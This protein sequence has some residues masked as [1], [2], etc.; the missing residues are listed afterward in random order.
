VHRLNQV[1]NKAHGSA[2]AQKGFVARSMIPVQSTPEEMAARIDRE[3]RF[4][5]ENI[6]KLGLKPKPAPKS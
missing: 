3:V 5:D 6:K 2:L 1:L 4:W